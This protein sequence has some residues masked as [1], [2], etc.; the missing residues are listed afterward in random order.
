MPQAMAVTVIIVIVTYTVPIVIGCAHDIG[1]DGGGSGSGS[2]NTF[3]VEASSNGGHAVHS[4]DQWSNWRDGYFTTVAEHIGGRWLGTWLLGA[5]ALSATGQYIAEMSSNSFQLEGM[6]QRKQ[7][8]RALRFARRSQHGTSTTGILASFLMCVIMG[9]VEVDAV[10]EAT[11]FV[12]CVAALLEFAAFLRL[13]C[14]PLAR[15]L[16][17]SSVNESEGSAGDTA[18]EKRFAIPLGTIGCTLMLLPAAGT[19][20][21][22]RT[23]IVVQPLFHVHACARHRIG[24]AN[25][26]C[27]ACHL[28]CSLAGGLLGSPSDY[29]VG[30]VHCNDGAICVLPGGK[31][32]SS[33]T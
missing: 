28:V 17:S 27:C 11:N 12:Y 13:R 2:A 25:Y 6:A 14:T 3:L 8:P 9:V 26:Q 23:C 10:I 18:V 1:A 30:G 16:T 33:C 15:N 24:T 4:D 20:V 21:M 22:V 31:A 19:I 7:L 32:L 5:A 29:A